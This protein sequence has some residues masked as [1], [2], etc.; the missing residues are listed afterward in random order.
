MQCRMNSIILQV[1]Q[2]AILVRIVLFRGESAA[3]NDEQSECRC[4]QLL[5]GQEGLDLPRA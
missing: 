1:L 4:D 3:V 5:E 2:E